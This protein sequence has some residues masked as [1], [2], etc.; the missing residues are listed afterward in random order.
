MELVRWNPLRELEQMSDRLNR[1][2]ARRDRPASNGDGKETMMVADWIPSLDIS[3]TDEA[4][5]IVADLPSVKK[6]DLSVTL[7]NGVLTLHGERR[8]EWEAKDRKIHRIE[9]AY[10]RFVRSFSLPD[11][12]DETKV[13]AEFK[14]GV[15]H[16]FLPKSE[17]AK[18]KAVEIKVA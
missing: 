8:E 5:H 12:V 18:P 1:L 2:F 16:L 10:G 7:N 17:Q 6:S 9:R 11:G 14:N 15:L 3:E 13:R 4:F